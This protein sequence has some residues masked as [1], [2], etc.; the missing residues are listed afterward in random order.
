MRF[1]I[2]FLSIPVAFT[3]VNASYPSEA[4]FGGDELL[5][6]ATEVDSDTGEVDPDVLSKFPKPPR[7]APYVI[8]SP[9]SVP[10]LSGPPPNRWLPSLPPPPPIPPR[11]PLRVT[12]TALTSSVNTK[13]GHSK[14]SHAARTL[15]KGL[16]QG[17]AIADTVTSDTTVTS[18]ITG[19]DS[20]PSPQGN[21]GESANK[22]RGDRSYDRRRIVHWGEENE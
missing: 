22:K 18:A 9:P 19:T 15:E 11:N 14:H 2:L 7:N 21:R 13:T 8:V 3:L 12:K 5:T 1:T 17:S 16:S 6:R 4:S 20:N 10:P